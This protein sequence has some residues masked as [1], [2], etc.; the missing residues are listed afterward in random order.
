MIYEMHDLCGDFAEN[1]DSARS[2]REDI[3]AH[4]FSRGEEIVFDFDGV[5]STT[6][7]FIHALISE[8]FQQYGEEALEKFVFK[9]CSKSVKSIVATV[10]N[11]SLE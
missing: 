4:Y 1:K 2:I 3:K 11:Y 10:I 7:S 8:F 5:D 9:N 6:Q